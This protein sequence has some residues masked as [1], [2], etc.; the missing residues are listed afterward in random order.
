MDLWICRSFNHRNLRIFESWK[1]EIATQKLTKLRNNPQHSLSLNENILTPSHY[2]HFS[3][4]YY[5][6]LLSSPSYYYFAL[7]LFYHAK[8]ARRSSSHRLVF[9]G[10]LRDWVRTLIFLCGTCV[11]QQR[12]RKGPHFSSEGVS[13]RKIRLPLP[14]LSSLFLTLSFLIS[15]F[16]YY[17]FY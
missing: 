5:C 2:Y 1:L 17:Y 7:P 6:P 15:V 4:V 10:E 11:T 12:P 16:L 3:F 14:T 9:H 13:P 8:F